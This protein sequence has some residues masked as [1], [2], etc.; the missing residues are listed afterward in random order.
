MKVTISFFTLRDA[1]IHFFFHVSMI[2]LK[3]PSQKTAIYF[4]ETEIRLKSRYKTNTYLQLIKNKMVASNADKAFFHIPFC[5]VLNLLR[6][7][8]GSLT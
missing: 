2:Y 6:N 5:S 8:K 4:I 7:R 3:Y 1:L